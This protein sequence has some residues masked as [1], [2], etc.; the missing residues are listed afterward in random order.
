MGWKKLQ[1]D[2]RINGM[3]NV[4]PNYEKFD[5]ETEGED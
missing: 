2:D 4:I 5:E 3:G 1:E